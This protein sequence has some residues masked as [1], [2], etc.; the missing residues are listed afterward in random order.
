VIDKKTIEDWLG[1]I[2]ETKRKVLAAIA[3]IIML[4]ITLTTLLGGDIRDEICGK[5]EN[6]TVYVCSDGSLAGNPDNCPE[7]TT[8]TTLPATTSMPVTSIPTTS[9]PVTTSLEPSYCT[10]RSPGSYCDGFDKTECSGGL[11][12]ERKSC[13]TVIKPIY[14]EPGRDGK[15]SVE[16]RPVPGVCHTN[17]EGA[18]CCEEAICG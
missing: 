3:A 18:S 2:D 17:S 8:L 1:N 10:G 13:E 12:I 11:E 15:P 6:I 16:L 9:L 7:L 4:G 14:G 5:P